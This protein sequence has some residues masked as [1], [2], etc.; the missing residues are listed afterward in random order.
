MY[1]LKAI[2]GIGRRLSNLLCKKAEVDLAQRAGQLKED[3]I[4]K[5]V[6]ILQ[7]P[8]TF[9]IPTWFL[10]R[11]RDIVDGKNYQIV[12]NNLVTKLREDLERLKKMRNHRGIRH[13]WGLKVR[14]QHTCT[15]GRGR[16]KPNLS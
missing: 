15:T 5:I 7:S 16:P 9:K 4:E 1:A 12:S 8:T 10:N 6:G 13:Y 2:P 11:R 14:G 3:D